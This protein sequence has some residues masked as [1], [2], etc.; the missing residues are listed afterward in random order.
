MESDEPWYLFFHFAAPILTVM[1]TYV[2]VTAGVVATVFFCVHLWMRPGDLDG[3][4]ATIAF[5]AAVL[6][7][8]LRW[9]PSLLLTAVT[10][11]ATWFAMRIHTPVDFA[12]PYALLLYDWVRNSALALAAAAVETRFRK[13][14]T[15]REEAARAHERALRSERLRFAVDTHDTVSQGLARQSRMIAL[16]ADTTR[17]DERNQILSELSFT[18]DETQEQI[19][20]YLSSL[21]DTTDPQRER[22]TPGHGRS[23]QAMQ[24]SLQR[25]AEACGL[26]L[27]A[28]QRIPPDALPVA[29]LDALRLMARE[30]T[31]NMIKHAPAKSACTL[32]L[33]FDSE[34]RQF[35]L[36][37]TN[38]MRSR[39]NASIEPPRSLAARARAL[40]GTCVVTVDEGSY[41]VFVTI[42]R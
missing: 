42:P 37:S 12:S 33:D 27:R 2:P 10:F 21:H 3:F 20:S 24:E 26:H 1:A 17:P 4:Q 29:T 35:L 11:G 39:D 8:H 32:N 40:G 28:S 18:N 25:A 36:T 9:I 19:R 34:T 22:L 23:L 13:T 30:L 31:T 15:Q 6:L 38:P 14:M 41:K 7:T 16:L 5:S